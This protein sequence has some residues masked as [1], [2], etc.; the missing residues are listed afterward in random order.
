MLLCYRRA[1]ESHVV[2]NKRPFNKI[3]KRSN[4]QMRTGERMNHHLSF[5]IFAPA[6]H[7]P[8]A[9]ESTRVILHHTCQ[10]PRPL[11]HHH[12]A[13]ISHKNARPRLRLRPHPPHPHNKHLKQQKKASTRRSINR[14]SLCRKQATDK[15]SR[16]HDTRFQRT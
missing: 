14:S 15:K 6:F 10:I 11:P 2:S 3:N 9:R 1:A 8:F 7:A 4:P 5:T 12:T 13:R 16:M